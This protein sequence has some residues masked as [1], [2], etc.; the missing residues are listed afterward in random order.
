MHFWTPAFLFNT[1]SIFVFP[2]SPVIAC[3]TVSATS[4]SPLFLERNQLPSQTYN[5]KTRE[6]CPFCGTWSNICSLTRHLQPAWIQ[7]PC[8]THENSVHNAIPLFK[9]LLD[10]LGRKT[11]LRK[12]AFW[13]ADFSFNVQTLDSN[14]PAW[15]NIYWSGHPSWCLPSQNLDSVVASSVST[16][17]SA[18]NMAGQVVG[19]QLLS[20]NNWI[21]Q[22]RHQIILKII[23]LFDIKIFEVSKSISCNPT[24]WNENLIQFSLG[25]KH[26]LITMKFTRKVLLQI[27]HYL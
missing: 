25:Y 8:Y 19:A 4:S 9:E 22:F 7:I 17:I 18:S 1:C 2:G 10:Y 12:K 23:E 5:I 11:H 20:L 14:K 16:W 6:K 26:M 21:I 27:S 15:N 24:W 13:P 3:V